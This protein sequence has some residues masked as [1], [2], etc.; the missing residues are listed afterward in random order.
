MIKISATEMA[1]FRSWL[2][3]QTDEVKKECRVVVADVTHEFVTNA[4]HK[5][6]VYKR[7]SGK[8][9]PHGRLMS[10]IRPTFTKD[11]LSSLVV[12]DTD[13]A[14]YQEFGTGDLVSIEPG[15]ED[16]AMEYKGKGI[17]KV[18]VPPK[19]YF[20]SNFER[21]NKRLIHELNKMGFR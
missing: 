21:A 10:S 9:G 19:S 18:N 13:Y 4:K 17:R 7:L 20:F 5:V 8:G 12:A 6:N 3:S 11:G 1:G 16:V 15:Y 2:S 14:A